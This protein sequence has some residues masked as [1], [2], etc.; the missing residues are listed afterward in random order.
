MY[1]YEDRIRAVD[2]F[3]KVGSVR[4]TLRQLGC[5][6]K[7]SFKGWHREYRQRQDLP[8]SYTGGDPQFSQEQ[9]AV[10]IDQYVTHDRCIA[11]TM[12]AL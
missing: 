5:P 9:K 11:V 7:N 6:A 8:R 10:A 12:R 1:S 4:S 3:F 2:L